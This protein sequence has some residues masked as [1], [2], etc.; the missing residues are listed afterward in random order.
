[1]GENIDVSKRLFQAYDGSSCPPVDTMSPVRGASVERYAPSAT[2]VERYAPSAALSS[3]SSW[4]QV[5]TPAPSYTLQHY[6][7]IIQ[8]SN[9]PELLRQV[10]AAVEAA[11]AR[12][13]AAL[14]EAERVK[15]IATMA[16]AES[17]I[18]ANAWTSE[19]Q[20]VNAQ[21]AVMGA[22]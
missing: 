15:R 14:E 13:K 7:H 17:Q 5:P 16:V 8:T 18:D 4:T 22:Q 19:A 2:A 6:Q 3:T 11:H 12:E 1:M 21:G 9:D 20:R 10:H